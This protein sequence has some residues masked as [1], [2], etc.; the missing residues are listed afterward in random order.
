MNFPLVSISCITYN[1]ESYIRQC[2][3]S[4]LNQQTN[5]SFEVLIHDDAS[6]DGT[7]DI[8]REYE[9]KY[10]H[11]IK[12]IYQ[13]ENQYSKGIRGIAARF[14][15]SRALGKYIAMCEGDDY[16]TDPYKLQKQVDFMEANPDY[17]LVHTGYKIY[18]V[19]L[20]RF[21]SV[22]VNIHTGNILKE[23]IQYNEIGTLTVLL[24]SDIIKLFL[25][26]ELSRSALTM[27]Y[28]MW[29][30]FAENSKIGYLLDCTAIYRI[31]P[32]SMSNSWNP[33]KKRNFDC[34][35][36]DI[37]ILFAKRNNCL[38]LLKGQI[39]KFS[40]LDIEYAFY[41]KNRQILD[42]AYRYLKNNSSLRIKDFLYYYGI[43]N[44]ILRVFV[45]GVMYLSKTIKGS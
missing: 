11:I 37:K 20:E 23:L 19:A 39:E 36:L 22:T 24:R 27:D 7:A 43:K 13:A 4:F 42:D 6:T 3:D 10:S 45:K 2:L 32:E 5:F 1:Q 29:L 14:N 28:M 12:P 9:K 25:E 31:L 34:W 30:Y 21:E 15:F 8:I 18:R 17:G 44:D 41:T 26:S 40:K 16:W 33:E 35:I 38:P